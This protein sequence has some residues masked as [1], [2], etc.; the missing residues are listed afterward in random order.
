MTTVND[1]HPKAMDLAEEGFGLLRRGDEIQ[2][3]HFFLEALKLEQEAAF[4]LPPVE[5]SEP[6]RSDS[7]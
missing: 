1:L 5:D 7:F 6:S 3:K 4:L 2:A